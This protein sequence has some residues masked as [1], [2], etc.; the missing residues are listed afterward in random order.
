MAAA[1]LEPKNDRLCLSVECEAPK[2][3]GLASLRLRSAQ[4]IREGS[5]L[6]SICWWPSVLAV[7]WG[8]Y[9]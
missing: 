8:A 5:V 4:D 1:S 9:G 7:E 3:C 2:L 6:H